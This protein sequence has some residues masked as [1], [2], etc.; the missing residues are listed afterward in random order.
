M[1]ERDDLME[2]GMGAMQDSKDMSLDMVRFMKA[3]V[4][5]RPAFG[6][7]LKRHERITEHLNYLTPGV[8]ERSWDEVEARYK[9]AKGMIPRRWLDYGVLIKRELDEEERKAKK[10]LDGDS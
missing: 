1:A 10:E 3:E 8:P 2:I 4:V 5:N 9:V 7:N 6:R